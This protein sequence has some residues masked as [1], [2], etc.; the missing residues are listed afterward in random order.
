MPRRR[1]AGQRPQ[2][3]GDQDFCRHVAVGRSIFT[4][5][6]ALLERGEAQEWLEKLEAPSRLPHPHVDPSPPCGSPHRP[7][8]RRSPLTA[9]LPI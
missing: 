7:G 5:P 3:D 9:A 8:A 6:P 1:H 4:S 2:G